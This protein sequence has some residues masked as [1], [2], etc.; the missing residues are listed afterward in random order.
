M[1]SDSEPQVQVIDSGVNHKKLALIKGNGTAFAV[2]WP[3]NGAR[4]R[5][6]QILQMEAGDE[7][8]DLRHPHDCVYYVSNGAGQVRD[9]SSGAAQDL[10]EGSI[11]HIDARDGY[12]IEAGADGMRMVG[13]PVP[14]DPE[15][16]ASLTAEF[17]Q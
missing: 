6:M 16:Y 4:F 2:L 3:G 10:I 8:I 14:A 1:S 7:T 17:A 9:L 11:V 5:T 12:R 15:L 13:G